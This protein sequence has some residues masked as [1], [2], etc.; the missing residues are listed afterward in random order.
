MAALVVQ[1]VE[2]RWVVSVVY[3]ITY[4]DEQSGGSA[5]GLRVEFTS[6]YFTQ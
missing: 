6:A 1:V 5:A 2:K 3:F 4:N